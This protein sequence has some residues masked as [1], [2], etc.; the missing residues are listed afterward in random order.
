MF[1]R[2][3]GGGCHWERPSPEVSPFCRAGRLQVGLFPITEVISI[4]PGSA[5]KAA[6]VTRHAVPR[7]VVH[8]EAHD[9]ER[10]GSKGDDVDARRNIGLFH[11]LLSGEVTC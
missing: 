4:L 11:H 7:T 1:F 9:E 3:I 5:V 8:I 2:R 6:R 10:A